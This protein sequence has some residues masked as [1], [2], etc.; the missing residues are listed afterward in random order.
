MAHY[1]SGLCEPSYSCKG[2]QEVGVEYEGPAIGDI[3][4][5]DSTNSCA[6]K[7]ESEE[8]C[9]VWVFV[10]GLCFLKA[11]KD[12]TV[13]SPDVTSGQCTQEGIT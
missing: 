2:K 11:S 7:C 3:L 12:N 9:R 13:I 5:V 8:K 4:F 6:T 10:A 1:Y